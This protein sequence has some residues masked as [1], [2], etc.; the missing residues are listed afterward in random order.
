MAR[1]LVVNPG[2]SSKK[3][4]LFNDL[5]LVCSAYFESD[6][7][8][9]HKANLEHDGEKSESKISE[10]DF[11]KAV[12]YFVDF[13][14]KNGLVPDLVDLKAVGLRVVAPSSEFQQH[15][16]MSEKAVSQ[17]KS[18]QKQAP[19]H[20]TGALKEL[21]LIK[22]YLPKAKVFGVSDSAFHRTINPCAR[23]Y[24]VDGADA[25][26]FDWYK[27]GYHGI[28]VES[29][30]DRFKN[31]VGDLKDKVIIGHLGSGV[32]VTAVKNGKSFDTSMG[33]TPL[34]GM[35][36]A[37][38]SGDID[39]G[40]LLA[41]SRDKEMSL[42]KLESYLNKKSGLLGISGVSDDIRALLV[43]EKKGDARAHLALEMFAYRIR[44]R[45]GAYAAAMGGLDQI[46]LTA[47]ISERSAVMRKRILESLA[48]LGVS[49]DHK[50]NLALDSRVG[51]ISDA[52][53][54][55]EVYVVPTNEMG[56]MAKTVRA[57]LR[58]S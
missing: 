10:Q 32:S 40:L 56:Q 37:T 22:H 13:L 20:I 39:T 33:F 17:L 19:L 8:G 54:K 49:L 18:L 31:D 27:F 30:I 16:E 7:K 41:M 43:E 29:V 47:T 46:I 25:K 57:F 21:D 6:G 4:A 34:E 15:F 38:R 2:S 36:M 35:V 45:I 44:K 58:K 11:S 5:D 53:S 28:S 52:K 23:N 48:F 3:Y 1:F 14:I 9:E 50:K 24:A 26:K 55:I 51:K 42:L 12:K